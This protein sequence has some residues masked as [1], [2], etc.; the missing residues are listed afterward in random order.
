MKPVRLTIRGF[1]LVELLIVIAIIGILAT[2][3]MP[4]VNNARDNALVAATQ[5]DLDSIKSAMAILYNDTGVYPNGVPS[6]CRTTGLPSNN[7]VD[8]SLATSSLVANGNSLA[9]WNGP[10]VGGVIDKWGTPYFLDEDY[11]CFAST[12]GCKGITDSGSDSSVIVSCGPNM[13]LNN[14]SCDY[15]DDNIVY[16]LC[17]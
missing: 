2:V 15:D 10:Y 1:T 4:A 3:V 13:T 12:T 16:R 7:E 14:G 9:G 11:Q 5:V 17:D 8:L 6:Y